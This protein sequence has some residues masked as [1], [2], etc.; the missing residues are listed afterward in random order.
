MYFLSIGAWDGGWSPSLRSGTVGGDGRGMDGS[1]RSYTPTHVIYRAQPS[2]SSGERSVPHER[3]GRTPVRILVPGTSIRSPGRGRLHAIDVGCRT[4]GR[5]TTHHTDLER[6][7]RRSDRRRR[8][9]P[10]RYGSESPRS[11]S[12]RRA[13]DSTTGHG[14]E[15]IRTEPPRWG[16]PRR[17]AA[18][19]VGPAV[20]PED[21]FDHVA[22]GER[23]E[24]GRR[25]PW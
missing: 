21:R 6:S 23:L 13:P 20:E 25:L 7:K 24:R 3:T 15:E 8:R 11:G 18:A 5:T 17:L 10:G 2:R 9:W 4:N 16:S 19:T 22:V 12:E 14:S 1:P